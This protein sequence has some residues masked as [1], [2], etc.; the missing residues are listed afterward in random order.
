MGRVSALRAAVASL[1]GFDNQEGR[2]MLGCAMR[3]F[4]GAVLLAWTACVGAEGN[5]W[6]EAGIEAFDRYCYSLDAEKGRLRL[7]AAGDGL[8]EVPEE[9]AQRTAG[10]DRPMAAYVV[11][12]D[13]ETM[14]SVIV[15]HSVPDE[16]AVQVSGAPVGALRRRFVEVFKLV[17]LGVDDVGLSRRELFVP[18]G[19]H[20]THAEAARRGVVVFVT[21]KRAADAESAMVTFI[22]AR[23]AKRMGLAPAP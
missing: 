6:L 20:G 8:V 9:L 13:P 1:A 22:P 15:M 17:E 11:D 21:S 7:K 2:T 14:A 16:C 4:A 3:A 12:V 19:I 23:N 18:G 5:R 10:L